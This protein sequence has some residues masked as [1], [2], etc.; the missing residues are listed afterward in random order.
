VDEAHCISQW[1]HDFRPEY[2]LLR[3]ARDR[4]APDA[5]VLAVTATATTRVQDDIAE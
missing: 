5:P 2:R 4:L 1:G 3:H